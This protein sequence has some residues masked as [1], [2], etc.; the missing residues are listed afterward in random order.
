MQDHSRSWQYHGQLKLGECIKEMMTASD[1]YV[2]EGR[3][4][5]ASLRGDH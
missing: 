2:V 1:V 4:E 3:R 5:S